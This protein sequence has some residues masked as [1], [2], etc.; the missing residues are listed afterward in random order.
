[1]Q[2]QIDSRGGGER[3]NAQAQNL[4]K[5]SAPDE[6]GRLQVAIWG[7]SVAL[8]SVEALLRQRPD[9]AVTHLPPDFCCLAD[10]ASLRVDVLLFDCTDLG[11]ADALACL[12]QHPGLTLV[13]LDVDGQ[14]AVVYSGRE[15]ALVTADDLSRVL[16]GDA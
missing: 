7:H 10:I 13:A 12:E 14:K 5:G 9:I 15:H 6:K 4:E 11:G 8:A 3:L 16:F 1:M 2:A